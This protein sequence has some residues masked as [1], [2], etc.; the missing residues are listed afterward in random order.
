MGGSAGTL[1]VGAGPCTH[2]PHPSSL[3]NQVPQRFACKV[4]RRPG[5]AGA[6]SPVIMWFRNDLRLDCNDALVS[7]NRNASAVLPVYCF[8]PRE[9]NICTSITTNTTSTRN[10]TT[11][12]ATASAGFERTGA[13]RARFLIQSV[14]DLRQRLQ[15]Q[16][17]D[18]VVRVGPPEEVLPALVA[19][20]GAARVVC[21]AEVG[22][23]DVRS[24]ERVRGGLEGLGSGVE[25]VTC[26]GSTLHHPEDLPFAVQDV[27][28]SYGVWGWCGRCVHAK[29]C[30]A[31]MLFTFPSSH[32]PLHIPLF[33]FP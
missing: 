15:A 31:H 11:K 22:V 13:Y 20:V 6:R 24:E 2:P 28:T 14:A 9:Y 26:W 27:P 29:T 30:T 17:S 5:I 32:S 25:L 8:D 16:G 18:L 21:H 10:T 3:L 19:R 4:P 7:A 23:E 33:T 12:N 1:F